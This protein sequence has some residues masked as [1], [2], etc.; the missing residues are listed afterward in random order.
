MWNMCNSKEYNYNVVR[1]YI[2][3]FVSYSIEQRPGNFVQITADF[4]LRAGAPVG[5][6][7]EIAA[8]AGVHRRHDHDGAGI[9]AALTCA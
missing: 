8:R 7:A 5:V 2:Y 4:M 3:A 1:I 9:G 6:V